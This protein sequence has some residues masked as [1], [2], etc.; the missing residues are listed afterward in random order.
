MCQFQSTCSQSVCQSQTLGSAL[1]HHVSDLVTLKPKY[2]F[3]VVKAVSLRLRTS[4][5]LKL[6]GPSALPTSP[7]WSRIL[8]CI[9][10]LDHLM[11]LSDNRSFSLTML[12]CGKMDGANGESQIIPRIRLLLRPLTSED[13]P[14]SHW[15]SGWS[16]ILPAIVQYFPSLP[17]PLLLSN[18][19][20]G[21]MCALCVR[22]GP[23]IEMRNG[24]FSVKASIPLNG[25]T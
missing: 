2:R 15:L 1:R 24:T 14:P 3:A 17:P 7:V 10:V 20:T 8:N 23:Q 19:T 16:N 9:I 11:T 13:F 12:A 6:W 21:I 4:F 25:Q 18:L 22:L 5:R